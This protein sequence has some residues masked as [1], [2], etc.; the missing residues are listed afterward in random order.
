MRKRKYRKIKDQDTIQ[1][2]KKPEEK[3]RKSRNIQG[4]IESKETRRIK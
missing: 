2:I 3:Y 1:A 4:N